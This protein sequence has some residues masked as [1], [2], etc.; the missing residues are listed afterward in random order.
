MRRFREIPVCGLKAVTAVFAR[1]PECVQRLFFDPDTG[2]KAGEFCK[3][4]A[5]ERR[6]YRQVTGAELARI[7]DTVHHGGIVA[8]TRREPPTEVT[9][10]EI[11]H[12]SRARRPLVVLDRVSNAHNLG[13]VVRTAAFFG[14]GA[15]VYGIAREQALPGE[16]AYRVAEGGMEFVEMRSVHGLAGFLR[17]IR[18][19]YQTVGAALQSQVLERLNRDSRNTARP[20]ALVLGNEEHGLGSSVLA[21]CEHRALIPG[22]GAIESLN[23]SAAAAIL[24][25]WFFGRE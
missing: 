19:Q 2:R 20:V 17:A 11:E 21:A 25:H 23:V 12:W 6:V 14:V 18:P 5:R 8:V 24:M 4:M 13:A 15:I 16:A 22:V 1:H 7:A 9:P 3:R 10:E